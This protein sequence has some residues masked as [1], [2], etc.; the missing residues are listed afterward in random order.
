[1]KFFAAFVALAAMLGAVSA[2]PKEFTP[3]LTTKLGD[4]RGIVL[5]HNDEKVHLYQGIKFG[6]K[7]KNI[8][9]F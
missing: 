2:E 3:V 7:K 8:L 5:E 4:I 9:W 6:N 1:M